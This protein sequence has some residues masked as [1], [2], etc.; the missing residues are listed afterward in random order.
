MT[1]MLKV[2]SCSNCGMEIDIRAKE[3]DPGVHLVPSHACP[4]AD[5]PIGLPWFAWTWEAQGF[6]REWCS[7]EELHSL[8]KNPEH[9]IKTVLNPKLERLKAK[10]TVHISIDEG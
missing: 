7:E 6:I 3:K 2:W 9:F 4:G 10:W 8:R 1:R 5:S